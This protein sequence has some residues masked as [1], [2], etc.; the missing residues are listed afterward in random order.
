MIISEEALRRAIVLT[1]QARDKLGINYN[2]MKSNT[3]VAVASWK[4]ANVSK[5]FE[6]MELFDSYVKNT[7]A[8]MN[9]I[10]ELLRDYLRMVENY[11]ER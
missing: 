4:D 9:K 7:A 1:E 3:S 6:L 11:F 8:G 5:Y 2:Y 10:I